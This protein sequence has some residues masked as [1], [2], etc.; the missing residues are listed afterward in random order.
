MERLYRQGVLGSNFLWCAD[1]QQD[2]Q[3]C[4]YVDGHHYTAK[5]A[6]EFAETVCRMCIERGLLKERGIQ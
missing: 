2:K 4:L 1:L 5:F 6:K 3:E